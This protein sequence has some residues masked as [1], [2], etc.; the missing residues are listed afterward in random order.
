[1][2]RIIIL[3]IAISFTFTISGCAKG[4]E[5]V[6]KTINGEFPFVLE[7][8]MNGERYLIEDTV[9]CSFEGHDLSDPFP[10]I[11]YKRTWSAELKSGEEEKRLIIEFPENTESLLVE[12]RINTES[13]LLLCYGSGGYYLGD[14]NDIEREACIP[15]IKYVEEYKTSEKVSHVETTPLKDKELEKIFGIKIIRFEFCNPIKNSFE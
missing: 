6:P 2:K 10:F 11:D 4:Y 12:G 9:I 15:A 8:E 14:P 1:M 3:L 7:Y 5:P 13:R